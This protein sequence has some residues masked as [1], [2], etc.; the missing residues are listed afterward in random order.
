M[1]NLKEMSATVKRAVQNAERLAGN[2]DRAFSRNCSA[3]SR[4]WRWSL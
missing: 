2:N 1:A 3:A 4:R